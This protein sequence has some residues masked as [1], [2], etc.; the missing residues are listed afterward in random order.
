M[1]G[2]DGGHV[3]EFPAVCGEEQVDS[4]I[5]EIRLRAQVRVNHL[6]YRSCA[7]YQTPINPPKN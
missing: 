7:V 3:R 5:V 1:D 2:G 6:P 4:S